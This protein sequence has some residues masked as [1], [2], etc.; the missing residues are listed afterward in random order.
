MD[1][2]FQIG[3]RNLIDWSTR[4][5]LVL[6]SLLN[7]I[8]KGYLLKRDFRRLVEIGL[9]IRG[10]LPLCIT[11]AGTTWLVFL[12]QIRLAGSLDIPHVE[13]WLTAGKI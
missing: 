13:L 4:G 12:F 5:H 9:R 2:Q 1:W 10:Y 6:L 8:S 3:V 11:K 7:R